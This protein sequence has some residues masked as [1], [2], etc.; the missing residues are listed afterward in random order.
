MQAAGVCWLRR[1]LICCAAVTGHGSSVQASGAPVLMECPGCSESDLYSIL[2][3]MGDGDRYI[4]DLDG[5]S[6]RKFVVSGTP[7][8]AGSDEGEARIGP[9]DVS[10]IAVVP[11]RVD[12][13]AGQIYAELQALHDTDPAYFQSAEI[14]VAMD[15]NHVG[16]DPATG[17]TFK[18]FDI[19]FHGPGQPAWDGFSDRL[20]RILASESWS[21]NVLGDVVATARFSVYQRLDRAGIQLGPI[22]RSPGW[23]QAWPWIAAFC[24]A[25]YCLEV[26]IGRDGAFEFLR[27]TDPAGNLVPQRLGSGWVGGYGLPRS[28][29]AFERL[30]TDL[31][32]RG[33]PVTGSSCPGWLNLICTYA[34]GV[35][36]ACHTQ[37]RCD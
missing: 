24:D 23:R 13:W 33:I 28:A 9:A 7:A 31:E 8:I 14:T 12:A 1:I 11:S 10:T 20:E 32:D 15:D 22:G 16:V 18:P 2:R 6:M 34:D 27:A 3:L 30:R 21:R 17:I 35:L 25:G 36:D 37:V 26:R 29:A 5:R 19:W 4:I